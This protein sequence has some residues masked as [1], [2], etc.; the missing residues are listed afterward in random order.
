MFFERV[1]G[2]LQEGQ[3]RL[4]FFIE[5]TPP[6]L[7]SIVEFLN[8]QMERS[9]V[10]VVEVRQFAEGPLEIVVPVLYGYT[11]Q[12]RQIKRKVTVNPPAAHQKWDE[13]AFF[14]DA[15]AR[16]G[17]AQVEQMRRVYAYILGSSCTVGWGR[18]ARRGAF[19]PCYTA[20]CLRMVPTIWSDG[21]LCFNFGWYTSSSEGDA[22]RDAL[23]RAAVER[24]GLAIPD[25]YQLMFPLL[26]IAEWGPPD[27]T[28]IGILEQLSK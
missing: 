7:A 14:A 28:L 10:L 15:T 24:L 9:E 16:L 19:G 21:Q 4:I 11:E 12:T 20:I 25:D 8:W 6:E 27:E 18:G 2:N 26:E 3:I 13:A 23:K 17:P 1:L 5:E 22:L